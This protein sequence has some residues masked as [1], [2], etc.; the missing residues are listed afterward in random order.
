MQSS[1]VIRKE[2]CVEIDGVMKPTNLFFLLIS[3]LKPYGR[4]RLDNGYRRQ[5]SWGHGF[6][7]IYLSISYRSVKVF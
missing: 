3:S 1:P 2:R 5:V 4:S 6:Q 7:L